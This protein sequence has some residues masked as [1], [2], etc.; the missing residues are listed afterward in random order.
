M[1]PIASVIFLLGSVFMIWLFMPSRARVPSSRL[2]TRFKLREAEFKE[3]EL[4]VMG[5]PS[6]KDEFRPMV[7]MARGRFPG[8]RVWGQ[9][10]LNGTGYGI[11]VTNG[12]KKSMFQVKSTLRVDTGK[13]PIEVDNDVR[14]ATDISATLKNA[15]DAMEKALADPG[16]RVAAGTR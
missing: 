13:G 8:C 6:W 2:L 10:I 7:E 16:G 14:K 9:Y 4:E 15:F 1:T 3:R 11:F 12:T 5:D